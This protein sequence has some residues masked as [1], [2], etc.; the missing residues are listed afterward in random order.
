MS[1]GLP[2]PVGKGSGVRSGIARKVRLRRP[3]TFQKAGPEDQP[4]GSGPSGRDSAPAMPV[5][6]NRYATADVGSI[7]TVSTQGRPRTISGSL[8]CGT[9]TVKNT[10]IVRGNL[11]VAQLLLAQYLG[12]AEAAEDRQRREGGEQGGNDDEAGQQRAAAQRQRRDRRQDEQRLE[13]VDQ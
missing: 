13:D 3:G 4:A 9:A 11:T 6:V 5:D 1:I 12:G 2:S 8:T 7:P 10:L